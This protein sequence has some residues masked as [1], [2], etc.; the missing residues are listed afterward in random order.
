[1]AAAGYSTAFGSVGSSSSAAPETAVA[2]GIVNGIGFSA[3]L[4]VAAV[5]ILI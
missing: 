2:R 1:M 4:W 5:L 3:V